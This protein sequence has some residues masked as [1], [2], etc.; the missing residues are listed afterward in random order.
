LNVHRVAKVIR[1]ADSKTYLDAKFF[2]GA[3]GPD[4]LFAWL[5]PCNHVFRGIP[6]AA[7]F[8]LELSGIRGG[9]G[10]DDVYPIVAVGVWS[11][12]QCLNLSAVVVRLVVRV[13]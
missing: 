12:D 5:K 9:P 8:H 2:V 6:I 7:V 1:K 3:N 13:D 4:Q 11:C 10:P